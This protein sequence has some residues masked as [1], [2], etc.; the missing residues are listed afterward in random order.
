LVSIFEW[1]E[2]ELMLCGLP[3]IDV[4]DMKENCDYHGYGKDERVV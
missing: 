1:K 4:E 3:D 2:M